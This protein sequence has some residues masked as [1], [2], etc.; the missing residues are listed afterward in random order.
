MRVNDLLWLECAGAGLR[1]KLVG[2]AGVGWG[3][4]GEG[5]GR[6]LFGVLSARADSGRLWGWGKGDGAHCGM[7]NRRGCGEWRAARR[8]QRARR[9]RG[10]EEGEGEYILGEQAL[11]RSIT[12]IS[13]VRLQRS[14][15]RAL[16]PSLSSVPS[17]SSS[18]VHHRRPNVTNHNARPTGE[19]YLRARTCGGSSR[20]N[21]LPAVFA[22]EFRGPSSAAP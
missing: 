7:R 8:R 13:S 5:E 11:A 16:S 15:A 20:G 19:H 10:G 9:W 1:W 3:E 2:S 6:E 22:V 18:A 12:I 4:D 21:N 17:S 14:P